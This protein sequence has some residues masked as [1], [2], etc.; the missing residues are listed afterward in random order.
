VNDSIFV[1]ADTNFDTIDPLAA[2]TGW[3]SFIKQKVGMS[4]PRV[5]KPTN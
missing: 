3:N 4:Q 1:S 2:V 5:A